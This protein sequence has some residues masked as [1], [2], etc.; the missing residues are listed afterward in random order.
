M[1]RVRVAAVV[2][3]LLLIIP[4]GAIAKPDRSAAA[5][6]KA[7]DSYFKLIYSP[8]KFPRDKWLESVKLFKKVYTD[9]PRGKKTP[10]ALF[11]TGRIYQFMYLNF[12]KGPDRENAVT[13]FRVLVR[14][15]PFSSLSDDALFRSGEIHTAAGDTDQAMAAYT[16]LLKWF[17][18]GDM[19]PEAKRRLSELRTKSKRKSVA[20]KKLVKKKKLPVF[21][22]VRFWSSEHYARVVLDVSKKVNY[23]IAPRKGE[24]GLT[25]DLVGT[26]LGKSAAKGV[27]P[28]KGPVQSVGVSSLKNGIKRVTIALKHKSSYSAMELSNP[29]RI[30]FDFYSKEQQ[31]GGLLAQ[32]R[33]GGSSLTGKKGKSGTATGLMKPPSA[34]SHK[35]LMDAGLLSAPAVKPPP[36][37]TA[38]TMQASLSRPKFGVKTI[39][40]DP[41]HGGKDPGAVGRGRLK[42]KDV[43]LDIGKRLRKILRRSC[44]CRVL[45]TRDRDVFIPLEERTALANTVGADLFISIHVNA[46]ESKRVRG[47]ET[48]FLSPSRSKTAMHTAAREN[49]L[50]MKTDNQDMNDLAFILSDMKNTDKIN[51]SSRMASSIQ[52]SLV[53]RVS[54]KY[55]LRDHG[56]KRG[57][58]YVLRGASMPSVL[59]ETAFITNRTEEKKLRS[60]AFREQIAQGIA[61]GVKKFVGDASVTLARR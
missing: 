41:G 3:S 32:K 36:V 48:Y 8:K 42:E 23:R 37:K 13:I 60:P 26:S 11:M 19:A 51:E 56:V 16:G 44:R 24:N 25:V 57:M 27:R 46:N 55:K 50:A 33:Q 47:A 35:G 38:P 9:N 17:P 49:M 61:D 21:G 10:D 4:G 52:K 30:V 14:S 43:V 54:R 31:S 5:Y 12:G 39:V 59:V 7:A 20:A 18:T 29:P 2:I 1:L 34:K 6:K 28:D 45:M 58:F 15:Y 22:N 40:I 53:A